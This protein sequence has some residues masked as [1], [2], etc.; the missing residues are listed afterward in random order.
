MKYIIGNWKAN[1]NAAEVQKWI[2]AFKAKDLAVLAGHVEVI[3]CPPFP[4]IPVL[5]WAFKEF[6]HIKIGAQDVSQFGGGE[7]TGEVAAHSLEG[8][9]QYILVGHSERRKYFQE[10]DGSTEQKAEATQ[11]INAEPVVLVR[12]AKDQIPLGVQFVGYEPV[13]AIGTGDTESI[14]AIIDM[15][16]ELGVDASQKFIYGGSVKSHNVRDLV[17]VPEIDGVLVGGASLDPEEFYTILER[18][19]HL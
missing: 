9:V 19:L 3:L 12:S 16:N 7:Y 5:D 15:K 13:D 11:S 14:P 4:F 6:D 1:K 10:T 18:C 2:D 8:I 17:S